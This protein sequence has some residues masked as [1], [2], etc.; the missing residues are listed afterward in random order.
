MS[1]YYYIKQ[2]V[3]KINGKH[4]TIELPIQRSTSTQ[5]NSGFIAIH[6]EKKAPLGLPKDHT[7]R[8][9]RDGQSRKF[10]P[11]KMVLYGGSNC[12]M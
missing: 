3:K 2:Y 1:Y 5:E 4:T 11:T 6:H 9:H 10:A 12:T 7:L 8:V